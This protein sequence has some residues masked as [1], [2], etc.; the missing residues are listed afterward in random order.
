MGV[1]QQIAP[2]FLPLPVMGMGAGLSIRERVR[3]VRLG[4]AAR[5]AGT[6]LQRLERG[7]VSG[8]YVRG[9]ALAARR[10]LGPSTIEAGD[11]RCLSD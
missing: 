5:T 8:K 9:W 2:P 10:T 11:R 1:A 3:G 6:V 4:T 7:V